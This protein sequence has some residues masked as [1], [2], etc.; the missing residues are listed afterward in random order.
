MQVSI[1]RR[2]SRQ[3][4]QRYFIA[5]NC[6]LKTAAVR[7]IE[8][9][10]WRGLTFPID[11]RTCRLELQNGQFFQ[12]G[13]DREGNPVFYFRNTCLGPWR[14]DDDALV[15]AVLHRLE[16]AMN[17]LAE[18]NP[19]V[20]CTL[21]VVM[22]RPYKRKKTDKKS[23]QE[24]KAAKDVD[25]KTEQATTATALTGDSTVGRSVDV[26]DDEETAIDSDDGFD[27]AAKKALIN[28]PRIHPDEQWYVHTNKQVAQRLIDLVMKHYPERLN[29]ALVVIGHGNRRYVRTTVGGVLLI[30][31]AIASSRTRDKIKF[32]NRYRD[33][34]QYVDK[35]ELVPLV[36]GVQIEDQKHFECE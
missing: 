11:T 35:A 12:Q 32:L 36:G 29:K 18:D 27:E 3:D 31:S 34:V 26:E 15:C 21:I 1:L 5:S 13:K 10:A 16:N 20:K 8:S 23:V 17:V 14:K 4:I 25:D 28:N 33:L 7:I 6:S 30:S 22:G 9:A 2:V 19:H 24:P